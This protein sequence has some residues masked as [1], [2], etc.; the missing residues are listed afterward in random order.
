LLLDKNGFLFAGTD[1]VGI[2]KSKKSI[3]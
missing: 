3:Y 2:Y 1:G